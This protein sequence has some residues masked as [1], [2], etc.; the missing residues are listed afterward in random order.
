MLSFFTNSVT[1]ASSATLPK[2]NDVLNFSSFSRNGCHYYM[3]RKLI[4]SIADPKKSTPS[5]EY[6]NLITCNDSFKE[7]YTATSKGSS[8]QSLTGLRT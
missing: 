1:V 6:L 7:N 4:C 2:Q 8:T 5:L 3:Q